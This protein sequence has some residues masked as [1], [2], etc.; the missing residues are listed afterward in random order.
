MAKLTLTDVTAGYASV[1]KLNANNSAIEAAIENTLSRDGTG[2][3]EMQS[4]LD[5]NQNRIYNLP[6]AT[7]N[8]EPV[9]LGQAASIA[10]VDVP[11]NAQTVGEVLYP[12]TASEIA[13]SVT[14]VNYA[15]EPG[16]VLRYGTNTTPGTTD[17]TTAIRN[18][19]LSC[20]DGGHIYAPAGVYGVTSISLSGVSCGI[21]G[22][23]SS[24]NGTDAT[25]TVFKC[26]SQSGAVLD[27]TGW[28]PPSAF[29]GRVKF[30]SFA[31]RGD[32]TAGATKY[33]IYASLQY[34]IAMR[35]VTVME[36]GGSPFRFDRVY[37]S[38]FENLV[39]VTPVSCAANDVPYFHFRACNGNRFIGC[40]LR[41]QVT[42]DDVPDKGAFLIE[43]DGTFEPHDNLF[44]GWWF[45]YLHPDTDQAIIVSKG[46]PNV[47]GD[48]QFFDCAKEA[49]GDTGT[50]F[51]RLA[52]AAVNNYGGNI[53]R[54]VIPGRNTG[55]TAIDYG[56]DVTQNNN[57][58][59]GTKGYRGYNVRLAS[60]VGRT[61]V[62][63]GG[64]VSTATDPAVE[65]N[66]GTTTNY[67]FD[68]Y[69]NTSNTNTPVSATTPNYK[70]IESD[71]ASG[72]QLWA[73]QIN[74]KT[75][76]IRAYTDDFTSGQTAFGAVRGT[77][78]AITRVDLGNPTDLPPTRSYGA[79][80]ITDGITAPGTAAGY[81]SI[82]VDTADGDLKV[83]FGDGTVKTISTDT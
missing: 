7:S 35:D 43:D 25:G 32:N 30:E 51:F 40:G 52:P 36:T 60:G 78:Q 6:S 81:A 62:W 54:G 11:F 76:E 42:S 37:L 74:N 47:F 15:Y 8:S 69:L 24:H 64:S 34:G 79:L 44:L 83:K 80:Q 22:D 17:M 55:S 56:V 20:P 50:C 41:S 70:L 71:Q 77:G 49:A 75:M 26:L 59:H 18:A 13:A 4:P 31:I 2:P 29:K 19:L 65:D 46:G 53:I 1:S 28:E 66:S 61:T 72:E 63:L 38:D 45:E 58:I 68:G 27:F 5:M 16:N 12:R 10:G 73:W 21:V 67:Y 48:F 23:G 82:Y 33:G 3:N 57:L 9:T 39:A 14:P